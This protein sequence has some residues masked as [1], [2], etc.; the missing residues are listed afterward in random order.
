MIYCAGVSGVYFGLGVLHALR[1]GD[2]FTHMHAL[3]FGNTHD[4]REDQETTQK[5]M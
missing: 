5:Q 1:A 2:G 3:S 4:E